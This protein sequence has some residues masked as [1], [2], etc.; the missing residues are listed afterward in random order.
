MGGH[1]HI[2]ATRDRR[3]RVLITLPSEWYTDRADSLW[4]WVSIPG[5]GEVV[6]LPIHS[7]SVPTPYGRCGVGYSAVFGLDPNETPDAVRELDRVPANVPWTLRTVA[8][9]R[10]AT[11]VAGRFCAAEALQQAGHDRAADVAMERDGAPIWPRGYLGSITHTDRVAGAVVAPSRSA[12]GIGIDCERLI[13][14]ERAAVL[15]PRVCPEWATVWGHDD[16]PFPGAELVTLVFSGK[17][18]IYKCLYPLTRAFLEFGDIR[19][20]ALD[21]E[22]G[23]LRC[24][25]TRDLGH[26]FRRGLE[27]NVHFAIDQNVVYTGVQLAATDRLDIARE[28]IDRRGQ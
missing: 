27:L 21:V 20:I 3:D 14:P 13:S 7:V 24:G 12:L 22:R 26:G 10:L 4:P 16:Q 15:T 17:E 28:S 23:H 6:A 5:G 25:L 18:S 1:S 19:V 2:E 9:K 11:F 8:P